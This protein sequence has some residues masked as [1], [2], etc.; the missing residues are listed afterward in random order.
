M[1]RTNTIALVG[2]VVFVSLVL[3]AS[4]LPVAGEIMDRDD[5]APDFSDI[6]IVISDDE[7]VYIEPISEPIGGDEG[8]SGSGTVVL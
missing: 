3:V 8:G 4:A 1:G 6:H 2:I 7:P 5:A